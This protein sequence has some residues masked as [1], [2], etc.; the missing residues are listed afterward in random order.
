MAVKLTERDNLT[1]S[2]DRFKLKTV[3]D[4]ERPSDWLAMPSVSSTEQKFVGLH[5]IFPQGNNF[6]TV[7]FTTSTGQYQVDWGD[8]SSPT[9]H[10]S[11]TTAEYTYN[12]ST[13][14]TGNTTLTS[15][16]YK[17]AIVTVTAVSGNLTGCNFQQRYTGQNQA[18]STGWL[19]ITL[20]LPNAT[21]GTTIV[22]GGT[23]IIHRYVES[24]NILTI[25][26]ATV[27]A[28]FTSCSSL[29]YV[30]L[31]N[32]SAVTNMSSMFSGCLMLKSVPLFNTSLVTNMSNMFQN[33]TSLLS[34]PLF[35]TSA[36]TNMAGMFQGCLMF[37]SVPLFNTSLVTTMAAI[38][39]GC[40]NITDIPLFSTS[41]LT[42][43]S[44]MFDGCAAL[45][46]V[47][48]FDTS[49]V[50]NMT[51]MFRNCTNLQSVPLFITSIVTNMQNM[52]QSCVSLQAIPALS[53]AAITT[54]AG[55]DYTANFASG[56]SSLDRCEM[57]FARVV[58]FANAQMS[59]DSLVEIFNNLVDRTG[60]ASAVIT[61]TNNYG[62]AA[63]SAGDRAI[64]TGKNWTITG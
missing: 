34:V 48:F 64:A 41:S 51:L 9:L 5:A 50:T 24:A 31:F 59:R 22:F 14:D 21:S 58:G 39:Q 6:C 53:T 19:D 47:P 63:L 44:Q 60:V 20:S 38:F 29:Q 52:F 42:T 10:N 8:G 17:Q 30:P 40:S 2:Q 37:K 61:I 57:I 15:R 13:Y 18:Y 33:C 1:T 26:G 12:Y 46:T 11:N 35:N 23:T 7:R 3:T 16:G 25:G 49:T 45:Q 55:T 56:C 43:M 28:L 4:W 62:A 36:V 54:T 32:T 27:L